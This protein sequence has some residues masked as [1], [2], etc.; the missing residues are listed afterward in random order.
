MS[1]RTGFGLMTLWLVIYLMGG[2]MVFAQSTGN[3][4]NNKKDEKNTTD[5][6]TKKTKKL[7]TFGGK[8]YGSSDLYVEALDL[9]KFNSRYYGTVIHLYAYFLERPGEL[10]IVFQDYKKTYIIVHLTRSNLYNLPNLYKDKLYEIRA[11]VGKVRDGRLH[12][13]FVDL[14][15]TFLEKSIQDQFIQ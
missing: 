6:D 11:K 12:M 7:K 3:Q 8:V 15:P 14:K 10:N 1:K 13:H 5:A 4:N 9:M 2:M